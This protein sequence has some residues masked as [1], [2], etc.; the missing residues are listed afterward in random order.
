MVCA[1]GCSS[2]LTAIDAACKS[3]REGECEAAIVV[4]VNLNLH[5]LTY[6]QLASAGQLSP[7][8]ECSVFDDNADGYDTHILVNI[9]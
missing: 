9:V 4:G 5:P 7:R 8:G 1:T 3:L 2:S 6:T